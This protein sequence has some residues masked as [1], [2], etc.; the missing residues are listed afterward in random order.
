MERWFRLSL[1][2]QSTKWER[3]FKKPQRVMDGSSGVSNSKGNWF[4][5]MFIA[6]KYELKFTRVTSL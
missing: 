1:K 3:K 6:S 4:Q 5:L 2:A